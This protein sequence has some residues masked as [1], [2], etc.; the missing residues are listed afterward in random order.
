VLLTRDG[1]VVRCTHPPAVNSAV[2]LELQ[3]P[4]RAEPLLVRAVVRQAIDSGWV[5]GF[6]AEFTEAD[7]GARNCIA[8]FLL[9]SS[10]DRAADAAA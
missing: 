4:E 5:K 2:V 10:A 8:V 6:R 3:L 7:D 9:R 1:A